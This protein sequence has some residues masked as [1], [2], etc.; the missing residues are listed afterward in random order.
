MVQHEHYFLPKLE[1]LYFIHIRDF[2]IYRIQIDIPTLPRTNQDLAILNKNVI[3]FVGLFAYMLP[4]K[5][6][7]NQ[8]SPDETDFLSVK[9]QT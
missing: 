1:E 2:Y 3:A 4:I 8:R 7:P 9:L 6:Y 5:L